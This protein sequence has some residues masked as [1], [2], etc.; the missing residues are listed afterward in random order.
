MTVYISGPITDVPDYKEK[1]GLIEASLKLEGYETVNPSNVN[2]GE[3]ATWEE[4]MRHD[5]KLLCDC[6][7]IFM[8]KGWQRSKGARVENYIAKKL[9]LLVI[10][11]R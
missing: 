3:N 5:I 11:E 6:D 10:N 2:L 4:Y 9:G 7:A 8:M 1:F